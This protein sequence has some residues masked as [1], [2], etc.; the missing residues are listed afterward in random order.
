MNE[1][2]SVPGDPIGPS[3]RTLLLTSS[4][5]LLI[6]TTLAGAFIYIPIRVRVTTLPPM[7]G[8]NLHFIR[9]RGT[10]GPSVRATLLRGMDIYFN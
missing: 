4:L 7:K 9:S 1:R 8:L 3:I 6:A 2:R 5:L 10:A